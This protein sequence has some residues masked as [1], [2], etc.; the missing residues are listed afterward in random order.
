M[1]GD[2]PERKFVLGSVFMVQHS[3]RALQFWKDS[4]SAYADFFL[5]REKEILVYH[6][7]DLSRGLPTH[8]AKASAL[9]PAV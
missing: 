7:P 6:S 8:V 3:N 9:S 5:H 1:T 2:C 4:G